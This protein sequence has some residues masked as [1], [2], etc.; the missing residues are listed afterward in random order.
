MSYRMAIYA[1]DMFIVA[2]VVKQLTKQVYLINQC[3]W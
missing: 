2:D 1:Y 3:N